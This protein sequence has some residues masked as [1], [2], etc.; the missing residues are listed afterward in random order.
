MPK[1]EYLEKLVTALVRQ[2]IIIWGLTAMLA[3]AR[4]SAPTIPFDTC[5]ISCLN[6]QVPINIGVPKTRQVNGCDDTLSVVHPNAVYFPKGFRGYKIWSVFSMGSRDKCGENTFLRVSNDGQNWDSLPG[7]PDPLSWNTQFVDSTT[8]YSADYASDPDLIVGKDGKLW[9]FT[10]GSWTGGGQK[11]AIYA[12]SSAD[13]VVWS[14]N[15]RVTP[16]ATGGASLMSPAVYVDSNGIYHM[17]T[18]TQTT[19]ADGRVRGRIEIRQAPRPDSGWTLVDTV[20]QAGTGRLFPAGSDTLSLS[21]D[22]LWIACYSPWHVG[23]IENGPRE[24]IVLLTAENPYGVSQSRPAH[25]DFIGVCDD[26]RTLAVRTEP[27]LKPSNAANSPDSSGVY[28][29]TGWIESASRHPS[30]ALLYSGIN[31]KTQVW[32]TALTHI[33]FG[34]RPK[35]VDRHFR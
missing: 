1:A 16:F 3:S 15:R 4:T 32:R 31:L 2:F 9:V 10:R 30:V 34:R 14:P 28:K 6:A 8:R 18:V 12:M 23:L 5:C 29:A 20:R 33:E 11:A 17:W 24:K 26:D 35:T 27:L 19:E 13:G 21:D 25:V 22:S 7:C